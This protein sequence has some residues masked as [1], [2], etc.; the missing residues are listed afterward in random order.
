[1]LAVI[2]KDKE[3]PKTLTPKVIAAERFYKFSAI[4]MGYQIARNKRLKFSAKFLLNRTPD[5]LKCL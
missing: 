3:H 5:L 4:I 1:M 2:E